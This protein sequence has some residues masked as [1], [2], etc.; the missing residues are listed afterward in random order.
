MFI[1]FLKDVLPTN[2][3]TFRLARFPVSYTFTLSLDLKFHVILL[4]YRNVSRND[5]TSRFISF[6][7]T[8][9]NYCPSLRYKFCPRHNLPISPVPF[10]QYLL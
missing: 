8:G 6:L 3:T 10:F 1:L 4:H 7:P 5:K 9:S 2:Q